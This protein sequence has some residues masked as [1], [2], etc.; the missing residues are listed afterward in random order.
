MVCWEREQGER[1]SEVAEDGVIWY[2]RQRV[3]SNSD[4]VKGMGCS[5]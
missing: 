2:R 3:W 5:I 4:H 1:R